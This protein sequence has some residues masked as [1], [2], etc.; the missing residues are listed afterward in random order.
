[1]SS[2]NPRS[3]VAVCIVIKLENETGDTT[4]CKMLKID[5]MP[6][7][8]SESFLD[9]A[10]KAF[11]LCQSRNAMEIPAELMLKTRALLLCP[12]TPAH[13]D[14][15]TLDGE[16]GIAVSAMAATEASSGTLR[17]GRLVLNASKLARPEGSHEGGRADG[18]ADASRTP[19]LGV[20]AT[21]IPLL[22]AVVKT[23]GSLFTLKAV[24]IEDGQRVVNLCMSQR[25]N[26]VIHVDNRTL[27]RQW[28]NRRMIGKVD[29]SDYD[30]LSHYQQRKAQWDRHLQF[31]MDAFLLEVLERRMTRA[32]LF[33]AY[34]TR[35]DD[36]VCASI[37]MP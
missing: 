35:S 8:P 10:R 27:Y 37:F 3:T 31:C 26:K 2:R 32:D 16:H 25:E 13:E 6:C 9:C 15:Y 33:S 30:S 18:A 22:H 28:L 17:V 19:G 1:M 12:T 21:S 11:F 4:L 7:D 24:L 14:V 23:D 34:L 5:N 29:Q 20:I 36:R